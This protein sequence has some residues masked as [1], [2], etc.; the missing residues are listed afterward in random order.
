MSAL[1]CVR[2]VIFLVTEANADSDV[3]KGGDP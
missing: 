1:G 3:S 2:D